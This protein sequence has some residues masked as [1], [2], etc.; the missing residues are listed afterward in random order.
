MHLCCTFVQWFT[1]CVSN[2]L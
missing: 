1:S 2:S